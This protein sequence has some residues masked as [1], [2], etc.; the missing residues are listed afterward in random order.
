MQLR[1]RVGVLERA[2][3]EQQQMAR[4]GHRR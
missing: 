4:Q 2:A 1:E 3:S